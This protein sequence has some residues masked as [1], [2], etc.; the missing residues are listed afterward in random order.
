MRNKLYKIVYSILI[1]IWALVFVALN[2][3][4]YKSVKVLSNYFPYIIENWSKD[5]ITDFTAAF[6]SDVTCPP[7]QEP[8]YNFMWPGIN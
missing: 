4:S 6:G 8:F 1:F 3:Y 5:I 2:G 7:D